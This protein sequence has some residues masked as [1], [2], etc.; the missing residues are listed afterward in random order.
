MI[1]AKDFDSGIFKIS[2]K[3]EVFN[4]LKEHNNNA[5]ISKEISSELKLSLPTI[6]QALS[7]L[8]KESLILHKRP[9][10]KIK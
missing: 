3:L 5:Y 4:F 8:K 7:E 10:Y 9:Y 1:T 6:T 2:H